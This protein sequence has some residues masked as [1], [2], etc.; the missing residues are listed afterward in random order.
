MYQ[1][2]ATLDV[3]PFWSRNAKFIRFIR[4]IGGQFVFVLAKEATFQ[5]WVGTT[6][7]LLAKASGNKSAMDSDCFPRSYAP[8][9]YRDKFWIFINLIIIR[10]VNL[11]SDCP[12]AWLNPSKSTS[13]FKMSSFLFWISGVPGKWERF[14]HFM[15]EQFKVLLRSECTFLRGMK[16]PVNKVTFICFPNVSISMGQ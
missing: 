2:F 1:I 3:L 9:N 8:L 12:C 10:Q 6:L 16:G 4:L 13:P 14:T 5:L 11:K 15:S 7:K